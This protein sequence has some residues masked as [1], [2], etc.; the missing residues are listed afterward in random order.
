M[1]DAPQEP[2]AADH[3]DLNLVLAIIKADDELKVRAAKRLGASGRRPIVTLATGI[4]LLLWCRK[5]GADYERAIDACIAAFDVE[6][7]PELLT[8][9]HA[10]AKEGITSPFDAI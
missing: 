3:A 9:A 5:Y 1:S 7:E 10:L 6:N 4:E 2:T 8:A